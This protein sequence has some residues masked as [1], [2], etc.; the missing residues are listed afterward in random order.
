MF[1][2]I[3]AEMAR[4]GMT[5]QQL[6]TILN[7]SRRTISNWINKKTAIPS[8]KL[9]ELSKMWNCSTDYLLGVDKPA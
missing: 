1:N 4:H 2:N 9:I 5:R 7:V 3:E 8:D 6:S